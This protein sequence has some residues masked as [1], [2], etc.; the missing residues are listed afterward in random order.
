MKVT[1]LGSDYA[2]S[3]MQILSHVVALGQLFIVLSST[4]AVMNQGEETKLQTTS[5]SYFWPITFTPSLCLSAY[6]TEL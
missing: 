5:Q 2:I 3:E 1:P 6:F 4:V